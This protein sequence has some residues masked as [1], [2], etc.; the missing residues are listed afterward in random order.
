[1]RKHDTDINPTDDFDIHCPLQV[2]KTITLMA[3]AKEAFPN[4]KPLGGKMMDVMNKTM[5]RLRSD[6]PTRL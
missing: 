3:V 1:M 6:K 2:K 4:A 5:S